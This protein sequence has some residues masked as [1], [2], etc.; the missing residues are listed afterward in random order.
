MKNNLTVNSDLKYMRFFAK[1][2][3]DLTFGQQPVAQIAE[4]PWR[5][6]LVSIE[7]IEAEFSKDNHD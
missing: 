2:W 1:K 3:S 5:H 6:N 7:N 4:I